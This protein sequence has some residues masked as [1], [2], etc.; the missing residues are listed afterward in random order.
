[1]NQTTRVKLVKGNSAN[2]GMVEI[3]EPVPGSIC[4]EGFGDNEAKVVC[5][6]LGQP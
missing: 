5:R 2:I 6:M 4:A 3:V 1:M